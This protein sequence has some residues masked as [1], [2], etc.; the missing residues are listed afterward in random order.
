MDGKDLFFFFFGQL[1]SCSL[2]G[3]QKSFLWPPLS[4]PVEKKGFVFKQIRFH[5]LR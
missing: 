5:S 4:S 3:L 2:Q 1:M